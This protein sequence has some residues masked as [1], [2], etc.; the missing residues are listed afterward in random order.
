MT[1]TSWKKEYVGTQES[2]KEITLGQGEA[3]KGN[4]Q[5]STR[6]AALPLK[7]KFACEINKNLVMNQDC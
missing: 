3:F 1:I 6:L 4:K 5:T 7:F 2:N